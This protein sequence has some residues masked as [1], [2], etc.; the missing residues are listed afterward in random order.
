MTSKTDP[1]RKVV[2][3]NRKARARLGFAPIY[4]TWHDGW[5]GEVAVPV[6]A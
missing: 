1:P 5:S 6:A 4:R 3:D 2:A